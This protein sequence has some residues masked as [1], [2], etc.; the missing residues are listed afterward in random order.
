MTTNKTL[1]DGPCPFLTCL[2][3][4][5]HSHP[6]CPKCGAVRYGNMFC[7][8]CKANRH[9]EETEYMKDVAKEVLGVLE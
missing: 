4:T 1:F 3:I 2:K 9:K 6:V 7:D 5:K 8:I